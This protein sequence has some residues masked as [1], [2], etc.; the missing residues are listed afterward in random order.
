MSRP[1]IVSNK[2]ITDIHK[3]VITCSVTQLF[4]SG[5]NE[6]GA[7]GSILTQAN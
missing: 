7:Q 6:A 3:P 2:G 5:A 4:W 1:A